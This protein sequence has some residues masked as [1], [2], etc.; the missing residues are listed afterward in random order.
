MQIHSQHKS[1]KYLNLAAFSSIRHVQHVLDE[2]TIDHLLEH[3]SPNPPACHP[4]GLNY[5]SGAIGTVFKKT[6]M[7]LGA[8]LF[9][10]LLIRLDKLKVSRKI[11]LLRPIPK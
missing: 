9:C 4:D 8:W 10:V 6:A 11:T 7:Q 2:N 5:R 1:K 3:G